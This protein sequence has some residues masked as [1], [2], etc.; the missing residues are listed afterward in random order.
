MIAAEGC[1][2]AGGKAET[3]ELKR[4]AELQHFRSVPLCVAFRWLIPLGRKPRRSQLSLPEEA[5]NALCPGAK[6][7]IIVDCLIDIRFCH[8]AHQLP[9]VL[10]NFIP[11]HCPAFVHL[12]LSINIS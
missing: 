4:G 9:A 3:A 8:Q 2:S 11:L 7:A 10:C 5:N 12:P 1:Q 6:S